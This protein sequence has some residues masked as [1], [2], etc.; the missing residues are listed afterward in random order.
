MR[1]DTSTDDADALVLDHAEVPK[2]VGDVTIG[3]AVWIG[4]NV[5]VAPG[6]TIGDDAVVGA[7]SVVMRDVPS[8]TIVGGVPARLIRRKAGVVPMQRR[9]S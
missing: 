9:D 7:N 4:I 6:V 3:N 5:V 2:R 8:Q 1:I